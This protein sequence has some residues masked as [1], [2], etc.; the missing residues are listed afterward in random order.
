MKYGA[1]ILSIFAASSLIFMIYV[2]TI[3]T[4]GLFF[5]AFQEHFQAE[6]STTSLIPGILQTVYSTACK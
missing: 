2:G 6:A 3:K 4:S 1:K 5:V